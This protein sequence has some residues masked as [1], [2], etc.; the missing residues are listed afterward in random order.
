MNEAASAAMENSGNFEEIEVEELMSWA[1]LPPLKDGE[2]APGWRR[3]LE[4]PEGWRELPL[5]M[6]DINEETVTNNPQLAALQ[7]L[8]YRDTSPEEL[9][10]T[11]KSK[12]NLA[13]KQAVDAVGGTAGPKGCWRTALAFY[14]EGIAAKSSEMDMVA[15]LFAN[16]AQTHLNLENYGHCVADCQDALRIKTNDVKCCYRAAKACNAVKKPDRALMFVNRGLQIDGTNKALLGQKKVADELVKTLQRIKKGVKNKERTAV[17]E[18]YESVQMLVDNGIKV[19]KT[20]LRSEHWQQ[21][22]AQ[23]PRLVEGELHMSM[24]FIYDEHNTSDFTQDVML[25]HSPLDHLIEMFPPEG[26]QPTWDEKGRYVVG[27]LAVFYQVGYK[28]A[29]L[30]SLDEQFVTILKRENYQCPG[31]LPTFHVLPTDS[32]Y[33][34]KWRAGEDY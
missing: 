34:K 29:E 6:E 2:E 32:D 1:E 3:R 30:T 9:A 22:G 23:G 27:K 25:Q 31:F 19:G 4:E 18:W 14:N 26:E 7:D 10:D 21:Y 33:A 11:C 24:L 12:G 28:M 5:F 17:A 8:L 15:S 16:R 20:E 13:M